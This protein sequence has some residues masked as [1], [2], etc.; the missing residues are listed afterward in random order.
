MSFTSNLRYKT[1]NF[2]LTLSKD[3]L[4][5]FLHLSKEVDTREKVNWII[6]QVHQTLMWRPDLEL[7]LK[8][9]H[10][11][12]RSMNTNWPSSVQVGLNYWFFTLCTRLNPTFEH[13]SVKVFCSI[14]FLSGQCQRPTSNNW[15]GHW[16]QDWSQT[17][18]S[19]RCQPSREKHYSNYCIC[20][21]LCK[22]YS[23][24]TKRWK[25][26]SGLTKCEGA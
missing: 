19:Q 8:C 7:Q 16:R 12:D 18:I 13:L 11:E 20:L 6:F 10:H 26:D 9:F 14:I 25:L 21:L 17:L 2:Y 22:F 1:T 3:N 23:L 24:F 5:N 4:L 15:E